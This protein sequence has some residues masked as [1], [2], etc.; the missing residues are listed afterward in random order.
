MKIGLDA[1]CLNTTH[2]R[3]MGKAL[4]GLLEAAAAS[5]EVMFEAFGERP[6]TRMHVPDS[7]Q[8]RSHVWQVRGDRFHM[9]EQVALP[10]VAWRRG[11]DVLHC[12]GTSAPVWQPLPTVI[13][14]HDDLPWTEEPPSLY[15][16]RV[17]P[18]AYRRAS[19]IVTPSESSARDIRRRWP[20]VEDKVT[21]IRWGVAQE[22]LES[23]RFELPSSLVC[24][25]VVP[26]YLLYFGGEI[27]RKRLAWAVEVW[28]NLVK[29]DPALRL[30]VCGLKTASQP[31]WKQRIEAALQER[32]V[33]LGFLEERDLPALYANAEVTLYPTL[34]EGFGFPA[35][36]SQAVGT[37]VV[38]SALGSLREL[39][40]PAAEVVPPDD[41][42]AWV[43]AVKRAR[44]AQRQWADPARTW[45]RAFSWAAAFQ[46]LLEV[47]RSVVPMQR[48]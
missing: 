25:G 18:G 34:Y 19:A 41:L 1:R 30:V 15:L 33:C 46:K 4:I 48:G 14:V 45:A 13:T 6:H 22:Y 28:R 47:Y 42:G 8:L 11:C 39:V 16:S 35:L 2:L 24:Q 40:G 17:L 27:P 12:F 38:F 44:Q 26:P 5:P 43:A 29:E 20:E 37:L 36:E 10:W 3:G 32:F 9:W 21:V 31:L 7:P 23:P